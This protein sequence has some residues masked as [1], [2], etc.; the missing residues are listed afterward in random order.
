MSFSLK[1]LVTCAI[2][3][4]SA[5]MQFAARCKNWSRSNMLENIDLQLMAVNP[6]QN[7]K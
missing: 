5:Y 4:V 1:L 2:I 6:A 3:R 7:L